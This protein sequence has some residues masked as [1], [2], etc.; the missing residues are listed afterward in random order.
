MMCSAEHGEAV[1]VRGKRSAAFGERLDMMELQGAPAVTR[2]VRESALSVV[3]EYA[4]AEV[5]PGLSVVQS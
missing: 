2:Q 4:V 3:A 1:L 5:P